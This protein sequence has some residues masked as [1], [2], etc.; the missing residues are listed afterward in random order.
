MKG[1]ALRRTNPKLFEYILNILAVIRSSERS[2][3]IHIISAGAATMLQYFA[4]E[5]LLNTAFCL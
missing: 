3:N 4:L 2:E 5:L 1:L